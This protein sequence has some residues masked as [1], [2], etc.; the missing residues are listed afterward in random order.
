MTA[1]VAERPQVS[2]N[3]K[4][5]VAR[6]DFADAVAWAARALPTRPT[7]P[8]LAG[9]LLEASAGGEVTVSAFDYEVCRQTRV[10]AEISSPGTVLVSGRLLSEIT[11]ALPGKPIDIELESNRVALVCG[12]AKFLLPAMPV[13]D[14]PDLPSSPPNTGELQGDLFTQAVIQVAVAA[15]RDDSMPMCT[16]VR[17]QI[18]GDRIVLAATDRY[19]LAVRELTWQPA[20]EQ[21]RAAVVV[22]A[23]TLA[24]TAKAAPPGE[25]VRLALATG[26]T[27][28]AGRLLGVDSSERNSIT[29]LLDVDFPKFEQLFPAEYTAVATLGVPDLVEAIKRVALVADKGA[30]IHLQFDAD[31]SL[32]VSASGSELGAAEEYLPADFA[33]TPLNIGFNSSYLI[34]GLTHLN[35]DRVTFGFTNSVRPAV[36]HPASQDTA[37]P[38]GEQPFP[39]L[40]GEYRYLI[41][42]VRIPG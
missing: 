16:G 9:M 42:P 14:Y 12:S 36:L 25:K 35:A 15:G 7:A 34:D 41:M 18:D 27:S 30:Q 20:A 21:T 13:E 24:E 11:K 4:F 6:D 2:A 32:R 37:P 38:A 39:A 28:T 1:A 33:G 40:N 26:E 22:P 19:R 5:R 31:G 29:R 8:I 23:K 10:P 17:V 3:A